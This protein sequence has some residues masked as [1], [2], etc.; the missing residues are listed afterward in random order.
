MI[1]DI[2]VGDRIRHKDQYYL[3]SDIK[4][5]SDKELMILADSKPDAWIVS[6]DYNPHRPPTIQPNKGKPLP[7][8]CINTTQARNLHPAFLEAYV[9]GT[10]PVNEALTIGKN[11]ILDFLKLEW[12]YP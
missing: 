8:N 4:Q 1:T 7:Q 3:V 10:I 11:M 9:E 12:E 5:N 6:W 2:K